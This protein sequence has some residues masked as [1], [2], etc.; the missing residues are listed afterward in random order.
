MPGGAHCDR[1]EGLSGAVMPPGTPDRGAGREG[2]VCRAGRA[3]TQITRAG[4]LDKMNG[5]DDL[6]KGLVL[7][8]RS[9]SVPINDSEEF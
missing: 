8:L 3:R 5:G 2:R 7:L 4:G 9:T 6:E 1:G